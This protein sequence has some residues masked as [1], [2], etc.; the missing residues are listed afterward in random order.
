[1]NLSLAEIARRLGAEV[2]LKPDTHGGASRIT[3]E[4][5]S[6]L[7]AAEP[8]CITFLANRRYRPL[9]ADTRA[10]A[11]ILAA[12]DLPDC[13]VSALVMDNPYAGYAR[14]TAMLN[15]SPRAAPGVHPSAVLEAGARVDASASIGAHVYVG[16]NA[17]IGARVRVRPG[18]VIENDV[19][20]GEDCEIGP[21]VTLTFGVR[22]G[23]R[24][25][26][27][28]G[29]VVGSDG[30]GIASDDGRWVKVPQIGGVVVGNDVE[31]GAN[32]TI[33]RGAL[34]DTLI[35]DGVKLDN[36]I[37]VG[38]NVRIGE[39]TAIAACVAIGGSARI[40]RRCTIAGAA[41]LAGHLEIA[42][43]VHLTATS[44]VANSIKQPGVYSSGM[45]VQE[46]RAWRRNVIRMRQLDE[47]ARTIR[48]LQRRL[49]GLE[50]DRGQCAADDEAPRE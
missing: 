18:T 1:M 33:D 39:H 32:T 25:V 47:M 19:C 20:I 37:Q 44:A 3:I 36:L 6:T 31:I 7:A 17:H 28:A 26:L 43:D 8:G 15:P 35:G 2:V 46:N 21:N 10:S 4:R 16:A 27:H 23:A 38:H 30:F 11:V 14:V 49:D 9:L 45:P 12:D 5:V 41:S 40:G 13:P 24:C 48:E 50:R 34:E 29:V 42:D 22:L